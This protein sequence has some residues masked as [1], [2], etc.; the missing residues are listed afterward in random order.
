MNVCNYVTHQC[1]HQD[2]Y[3]YSVNCIQEM[4]KKCT[5]TSRQTLRQSWSNDFG[6]F[7]LSS[8]TEWNKIKIEYMYMYI[9]IHVRLYVRV[10]DASH[11]PLPINYIII[12][13]K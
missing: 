10:I 11:E 8:L 5:I 6:D 7:V 1:I 9:M 4:H 3:M 12:H 2:F 13:Y